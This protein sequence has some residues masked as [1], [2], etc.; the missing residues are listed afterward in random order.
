VDKNKFF[1]LLYFAIYCYI[2]EYAGDSKVAK[3]IAKNKGNLSVAQLAEVDGIGIAKAAQIL[4]GFELAR[5]YINELP[6][7]K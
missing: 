4:A 5:R 7:R 3:L 6:R 1:I 2:F